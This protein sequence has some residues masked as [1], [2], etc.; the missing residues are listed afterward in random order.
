MIALSGHRAGLSWLDIAWGA[1]SR[2]SRNPV[3]PNWLR[4]GAN[5][6]NEARGRMSHLRTE[7]GVAWR[8]LWRVGWPARRERNSSEAE[9]R[10]QCAR[11][12]EL[13]QNEVGERVRVRAVLKRELGCV[14]RRRGRESRCACALV[15]DGSRGRRS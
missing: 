15:H 8:D 11:E 4:S 7:L 1:A 9:R 12:D 6:E 10:E 5:K 3:R 14:G 2:H 13:A